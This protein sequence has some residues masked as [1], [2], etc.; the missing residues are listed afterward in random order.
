MKISQKGIDHIKHFEGLK[1]EAYVDA[2]GVWTIGYGHT[3]GVKRG[4]KITEEKAE[5][6]LKKDL[7]FFEN[8]V[9]SLL[10]ERKLPVIDQYKFD[11]LVSFSYNLG[12]GALRTSTLLKK[13]K[14]RDFIGASNEFPRWV[15]V[16]NP[17]N[18]IKEKNEWQ[19]YRRESE[20]QIFLGGYSE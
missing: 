9:T 13:L 11:M 17:K 20:R 14:E 6:L 18:G 3:A 12:L 1:L 10:N 15:F 19:M 4:D 16:T 2:A 5:K 7:Q 8:G